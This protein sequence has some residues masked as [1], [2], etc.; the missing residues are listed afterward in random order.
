MKKLSDRTIWEG[1]S[2]HFRVETI[3]L[4]D[5]SEMERGKIDHPG[6]VVLVPVLNDG[7]DPH[8]ILIRQFRHALNETILELPAGTR[9]WNEDWELCAQRE[10]Q[11]ETGFRADSFKNLGE[12][13]PSPGVSN[14]LMT[15]YLATGLHPDPLPADADEEI[16]VMPTRL[17]DCLAMVQNGRIRDAK[18][19]IGLWKTAMNY[20]MHL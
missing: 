2:W 5:K 9:G 15:L 20:K 1:K 14:E 13:L 17:S 3:A 11:E 7:D 10:L 8:V 4:P 19:I 6:A 18:T 16:E 12:I